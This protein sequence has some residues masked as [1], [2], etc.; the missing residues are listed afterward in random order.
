MQNCTLT[1]QIAP[2][3]SSAIRPDAIA[4]IP[5]CCA[6]EG[7][8]VEEWEGLM[9]VLAS[10]LEV[11]SWLLV[12]VP[13]LSWSRET[14]HLFVS[15]IRIY[16]PS[17][18]ASSDFSANKSPV[19]LQKLQETLQFLPISRRQMMTKDSRL[20]LER[21]QW[22]LLNMWVSRVVLHSEGDLFLS[23]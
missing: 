21:R 3:M 5:K 14:S 9:H 17:S 1:G 22:L 13:G 2:R 19:I 11:S 20:H 15:T 6:P 12:P 23:K 7:P 10:T 16:H 4:P 8:I 18:S